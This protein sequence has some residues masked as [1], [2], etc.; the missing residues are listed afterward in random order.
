[1]IE[2]IFCV[3]SIL[4]RLLNLSGTAIWCYR[5]TSATPGCADKFNWRGIGY[6]G[7]ACP[8]NDDICVKVTEKKGGKFC[9]IS[10]IFLFLVSQFRCKSILT[11]TSF[12]FDVKFYRLLQSILSDFKKI[13]NFVFHRWQRLINPSITNY[14]FFFQLPS[15]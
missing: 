9:C 5:C 15:Q 4:K 1:M 2:T 14:K 10:L 8:E 6:L 7:E 13:K 11:L 3:P 12:S